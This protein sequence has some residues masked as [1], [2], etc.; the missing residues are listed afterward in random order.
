MAQGTTRVLVNVCADGV[1][2]VSGETS[3]ECK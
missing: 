3:V 1:T 2:L